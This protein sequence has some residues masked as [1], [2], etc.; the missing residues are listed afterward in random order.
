[1]RTETN[2]KTVRLSDILERVSLDQ[3]GNGAQ[4]LIERAYAVAEE[5]HAGQQ[6]DSGDPYIQHPLSVA[7]L[8]ADIGMGPDTVA[9][10][11]LHDVVEDTGIALESLVE[12]RKSVV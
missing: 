8:L 3:R 6:R 9:A 1:M 5:A 10:G 7:L 2:K 4:V 12:D 11:L